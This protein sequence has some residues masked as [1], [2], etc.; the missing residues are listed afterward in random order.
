MDKAKFIREVVDPTFSLWI[1][2][3]C[4]E[5]GVNT[6]VTCGS[7]HAYLDI[8][9]GHFVKRGNMA[10]RYD[11][12]NVAPQCKTCNRINE[13]EP[14]KFEAYLKYTYG[15]TAVQALKLR[16]KQ[17]RNYTIYELGNMVMMWRH[18]IK[19]WKLIQDLT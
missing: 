16:G 19:L 8:D 13:G 15:E 7:L 1:R 10:V 11:S 3:G 12:M 14:K 9:A 18:D 5:D 17:V 2:L 6:C 4:S